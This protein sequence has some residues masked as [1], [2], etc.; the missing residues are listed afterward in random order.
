M[1]GCSA[2]EGGGREAGE[3]IER[4]EGAGFLTRIVAPASSPAS[5]GFAGAP[6]GPRLR[7]GFRARRP[8]LDGGCKS[9]PPEVG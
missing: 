8:A 5:P 4:D 2:A 7:L 1:S 3:L 6:G 9:P